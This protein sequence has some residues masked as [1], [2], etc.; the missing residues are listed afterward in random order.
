MKY[1]GITKN[2]RQF[3]SIIAIFFIL[4]TRKNKMCKAIDLPIKLRFD[5]YH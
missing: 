4:I 3:D 1:C 5:V 2:W